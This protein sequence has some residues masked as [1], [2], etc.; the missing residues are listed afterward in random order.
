MAIAVGV[1]SKGRTASSS[2]IA[3]TGVATQASGSTFVI[4]VVW[5]NV[6]FTSVTDNK[7]NTYTQLGGLD[8]QPGAAASHARL[9]YCQNGNGGAG[10]TGTLTLAGAD[11]CAIFF[12]EITGALA[13][14]FDLGNGNL[15]T[16][17]PFTSPSITTTQA[18]E[19]LIAYLAGDS[20]SNPATH[21]ES[22]GFTVQSAAEETNGSSFWTGCL[23]SRLVTSTASYNASFT[24]SGAT[25]GAV[26]V[27]GFKEAAG[28]ATLRTNRRSLL[29]VGV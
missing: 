18:R 5:N 22:T 19:L 28:G 14:S 4:G 15:D 24:E 13:A 10:H 27:I 11:N 7:T 23:A 8:L 12:L 25:R 9:Y 6:G 3:T 20:G 2:S 17:S 16:A 26:F 29:G 21:A 1:T